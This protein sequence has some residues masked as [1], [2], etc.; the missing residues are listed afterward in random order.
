MPEFKNMT[1]EQLIRRL[2]AGDKAVM[3]Y[4]MEKYKNL[5]RKEGMPCTFWGARRMI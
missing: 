4:I 2:R 5:V 3:D 1:D